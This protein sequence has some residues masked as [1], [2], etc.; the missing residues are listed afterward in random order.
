[1]NRCLRVHRELKLPLSVVKRPFPSLLGY[2]GEARACI[3]R[4]HLL[5]LIES[6]LVV[7]YLLPVGV[8]WSS[9]LSDTQKRILVPLSNVVYNRLPLIFNIDSL[10]I[11]GAQSYRHLVRSCIYFERFTPLSLEL[12]RKTNIPLLLSSLS[13]RHEGLVHLISI[14]LGGPELTRLPVGHYLLPVFMRG[15]L[16]NHHGV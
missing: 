14:I 16:R 15:L 1:M 3:L 4:R 2:S 12:L 9:T 13:W 5:P 7:G 11:L 10:W 6:A 8:C